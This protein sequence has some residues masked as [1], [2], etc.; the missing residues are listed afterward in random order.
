LL[1]G[2]I[3]DAVLGMQYFPLENKQETIDLDIP[4][5]AQAYVSGAFKRDSELW[6][7]FSFDQLINDQNYMD[8]AV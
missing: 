2:L 3:V 8:I 7:V 6:P 1:N 4:E 5:Q